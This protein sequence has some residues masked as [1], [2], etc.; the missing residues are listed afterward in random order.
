MKINQQESIKLFLKVKSPK[1]IDEPYYIIDEN[2]K[3]FSLKSREKLKTK[4]NLINLNLDEIFHE[5]NTIN[6]IYEKTCSNVIKESLNGCSFCFVNHGETISD[7]LYTLMGDIEN[8]NN[9][10]YTKG[11]FQLLYFELFS[12]IEK[13]KKEYSNI[14]FQ[15]SFVCI[16]NSRVIDLNNFF[17]KEKNNINIKTIIQNP[18]LIQNDK[19]LINSIKK[20]SLDNS[21]YLNILSF[22][23]KIISEFQKFNLDYF[24]NSYFSI[25]IYID[26]K[27]KKEIVPLSNITFILLNGSEKLNIIDNIKLSKNNLNEN[28][29]LKKRAINASKN[30]ISTQN[31]YN[32]IIY[33][34]KQNK[35]FNINKSKNKGEASLTKEELKELEIMEGRYISSLTA[36][37][38]QICFDYKIENIKY[39]F[40]CNIFPNIGY[41]KSVKDT[42]LFLLDLSKILNKNIKEKLNIEKNRNFLE[43]NFLLDLENLSK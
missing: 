27:V 35:A 6:E 10:N 15:Y 31:N 5:K 22:I 28:S 42:I 19:S 13:N 29:D 8:I 33:L 40:Y 26:K 36:L 16:N 3:I 9:N 41:Y 32:S 1:I 24:S 18:K 43:T 38:Y 37:L 17:K 20:I 39:Y 25:I 2:K 21:N 4:E 7:K 30:A 11:I 34:V 14:S 23:N 12:Y